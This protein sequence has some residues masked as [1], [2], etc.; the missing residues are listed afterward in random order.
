MA[1]DRLQVRRVGAREAGVV[2]EAEFDTSSVIARGPAR[3]ARMTSVRAYGLPRR[4]SIQTAPRTTGSAADTA[5]RRLGPSNLSGPSGQRRAGWSARPRRSPS[6]A[7]WPDLLVGRPRVAWRRASGYR[8]TD[9][10]DRACG[11]GRRPGAHPGRVLLRRAG[12][13]RAR[14]HPVERDRVA[15]LGRGAGVG[16]HD[17][18]P[19]RRDRRGA[20]RRDAAAAG[21]ARLDGHRLG[22]G[23]RRPAAG[24]EPG[25]AAAGV[26]AQV[27]RR[28]RVGPRPRRCGADAAHPGQRVEP[29][30]RAGL[31]R[32]HALRGRERPGGRLHVPG[33]GGV[34]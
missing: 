7:G 2:T 23:A 12:R 21:P 25:R 19:A 29:A 26:A 17:R 10:D 32:H 14:R 30:A 33:R 24:L 22:P 3:S 8:C 18:A 27:R 31:H 9:D 15:V 1:G 4:A 28:R 6:P 34:G 16:R 20:V 13:T 11:G 5:W